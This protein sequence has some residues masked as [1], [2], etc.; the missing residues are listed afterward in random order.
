MLVCIDEKE[1]TCVEMPDWANWYAVD[2]DGELYAFEHE[3][4]Y[5]EVEC[6]W[7]T[8]SGDVLICVV[9]YCKDWRE[10]K[11]KIVREEG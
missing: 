4:N 10:T 8:H 2:R 11:T 7:W 9:K 6:V 5:D 1:N 3:P